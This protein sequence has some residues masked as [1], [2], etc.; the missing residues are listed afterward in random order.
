MKELSIDSREFLNPTRKPSGL[1]KLARKVI[2]SRLAE[3]GEGVISITEDGT[4]DVYGE[5]TDSMPLAA[6]IT[7]KDPRFYS[8]VAFGGTIGSGEAFIHDYWECD[9]L[10]ALVRILLRNKHVLGNLDSGTAMFTRPLQRLFHWL[11]RNTQE[12]SRRNIAAHYDLGN[13]FYALWLDPTMMYSSGVYARPDMTLEEASVYKLDLICR[14][15]GLES[16][17]R[18][19]EIG[20]GWGGFAMHAAKHY[21][22]HVTTTTISKEQH[23]W[24]ERAIREAGLEDRITLLLEDYRDLGG[25]FDKLV[26]IEMIEAVGHEY[27]DTFFRKCAE[28]LKPDGQMLLQAITI[29]DQ[30]YASYKKGVDFIKRYI[31]PGGCLTSVTGMTETM[32]RVTDMRAVHIEDIGPHY[33]TTL[34]AWRERFFATLDRVRE[35]GYSDEFIR[36]WHYYLAYCE[37]GFAERAIGNVHMLVMRPGARPRLA[38]DWAC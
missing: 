36:M 7:V 30:Q 20:T 19:I 26:S 32:T 35:L 10:T 15:L 13:D 16:S 12:G 2:R 5:M 34:E 6:H 3:V 18:V 17:D 33:A 22:C 23:A 14:K 11:N 27:H 9:D 1:D 8:E 4:A 37:G 24:A 31:F 21:G 29:A 28:L 38:E 25:Q